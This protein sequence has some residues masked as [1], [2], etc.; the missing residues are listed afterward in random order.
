MTHFAVPLYVASQLFIKSTVLH[1][2]VKRPK[3]AYIV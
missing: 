1:V 3:V 2:P